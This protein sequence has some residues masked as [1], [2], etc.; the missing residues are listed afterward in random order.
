MVS[1]REFGA[2]WVGRV[3]LSVGRV[4]RQVF[5]VERVYS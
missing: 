5:F 3:E 1:C 2:A 4:R